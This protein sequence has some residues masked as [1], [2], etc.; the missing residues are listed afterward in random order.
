M[1]S[2]KAAG[3]DADK[4]TL[5]FDGKQF[6]FP[7]LT[8]TEGERAVDLT[9]LRATTGLVGMD[10]GYA[11]TASCRSAITFIDGE[12]GILKY[13]G[14][15]IEEIAERGTFLETSWLLINGGLPT[16]AELDDFRV[17]VRQHTMLHEDIKRFYA[18]FPK[19]AHP[20]AICSA[21]VGAL[22]AF[23]PELL[24]SDEDANF[25]AI[26]R[27][28]AK[29]PT[30]AAYSFKHS[31]GQPF[32]YPRNDLGY[33]E[34]FMHMMFATPCEP[35]EIDPVVSRALD[36]LLI[37][38][39]DHEQNCS[40]STVRLVG[41]SRANLFACISAG[42][43]AL[44]GP[45]HGGA[46][47][48]VIEMLE[49]I[50]SGGGSVKDFVERAKSRDDTARLM[51]FGHR[52]YKNYDPRA[53]IIRQACH[54][55]VGKLGTKSRA[56]EIAMELEEI[57]IRD[58]YFVSRKLYPNVDFYS[59]IIY[60]TI[61]VPINMFTVLFA[62]GRLPGWV[63]QW[64]ELQNDPFFNDTATTEI[65]TGAIDQHMTDIDTRR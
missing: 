25:G 61:G 6:E 38:H 2:P 31:I 19:K 24:G 65:Y 3:S 49:S 56:L 11:N 42:I 40:T 58:E 17:R 26:L 28:I 41:S 63:A 33:T 57:A 62:I 43:N 14:I 50:A 37:L 13:R 1:P 51:G 54:D 60:Q 16:R 8:G 46:N 21:V 9:R 10:P 30:I 35:Y 39:A 32:M 23:Y 52:V 55:I 48:K 59:G 64:L 18:G 47:Q 4:A 34:N 45:L 29:L 5:T 7:M 12:Q 27:L 22:S 36:T 53:R 15:P 20:M 44:W